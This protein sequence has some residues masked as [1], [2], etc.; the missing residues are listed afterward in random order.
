MQRACIGAQPRRIAERL[1]REVEEPL[2][3]RLDGSERDEVAE[4]KDADEKLVGELDR[5]AVEAAREW[6]YACAEEGVER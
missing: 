1:A 6:L 5:D 3:D 4:A 2:A